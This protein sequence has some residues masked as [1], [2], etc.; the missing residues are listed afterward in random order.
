MQSGLYVS[1]SGQ[2]A[3][4]RRLETIADNVANANTVGF[5]AEQ[6]R[7]ETLLSQAS[8]D[9]VAFASQGETHL[10]RRSGEIVRTDNLLDVAVEGDA[11]LA[12]GTPAGQV[13]TRDGRMRMTETGELQTLNG[14]ALLDV[15]G[16][17]ILLDPNAGPPS[18]ARDGTITQSGRQVGV[19][20]LFL[21][22]ENAV[23]ARYEN[24]GVIPD[25][26]ATPL[27]DF[28]NAGVSQGY[29]ERSNVNPVEEMTRLIMVSRAF[30][31]IT[32]SLSE[33]ETTK[34]EAVKTLGATS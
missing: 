11:W 5:R 26:A 24:S 34:K 16:A 12:I 27:L 23:L 10:S 33:A 21:I 14:Q 18:I 29:V 7:F 19:L 22:D 8:L 1:L 30:E 9:P 20:G 13:Y 2:L 17:P 28:T 3:L 6:V 32:N 31:A 25:R 15:G 4:Q